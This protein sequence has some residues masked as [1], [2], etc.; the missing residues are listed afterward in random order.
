M[1]LRQ[2]DKIDPSPA[3]EVAFGIIRH[4]LDGRTTLISVEGELD[5]ST[6]P[7]LKW[8]LVDALDAGHSQLVLDLSGSTFMDSTAL[9]VLIGINRSLDVGARLAIAC[10]Q[11]TVLNVFELSG[12]DGAF[13]IFPTLGAALK[14]IQ[15][16]VAEAR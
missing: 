2:V 5:L 13:T 12:M 6:A 1:M 10:A 15:E 9:G 3:V 14:Y 11:A 16:P 4:D 8:T 7:Q